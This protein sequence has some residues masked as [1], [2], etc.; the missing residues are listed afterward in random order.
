MR[1]FYEILLLTLLPYSDL[2]LTIYIFQHEMVF[3]HFPTRLIQSQVGSEKLFAASVSFG[4][5]YES[6]FIIVC[7]PYADRISEV[8]F[9]E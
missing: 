4:E 3:K 9:M 2:T 8:W 5:L 1:E 6:L 7:C